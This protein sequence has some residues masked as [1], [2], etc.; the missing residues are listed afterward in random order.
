MYH[1]ECSVLLTR[2]EYMTDP[3]TELRIPHGSVCGPT[4]GLSVISSHGPDTAFPPSLFYFLTSPECYLYY[5]TT[6][7]KIV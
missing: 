4:T 7:K 5:F 2:L 1:K 3:T 6:L